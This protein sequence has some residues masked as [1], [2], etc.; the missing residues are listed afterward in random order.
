MAGGDV[1]VLIRVLSLGTPDAS[2]PDQNVLNGLGFMWN[3]QSGEGEPWYAALL[4]PQTWLAATGQIFFSL[5]VGFGIIINYSSYIKRTDD[6]V[7][8][9]LTAASTNGFFQWSTTHLPKPR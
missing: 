4:N 8:S 1:T 5:S 9:G 7:L 2:K 6:F 3:P